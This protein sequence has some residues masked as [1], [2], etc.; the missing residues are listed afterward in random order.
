M[1]VF[2]PCAVPN[3]DKRDP[4]QNKI[5]SE[6]NLPELQYDDTRDI[7]YG[8]FDNKIIECK[9]DESSILSVD[10]VKAF[11]GVTLT[12]VHAFNGDQFYSV[13]DS[14]NKNYIAKGAGDEIQR[15]RY[16][17][18]YGESADEIAV[19]NSDSIVVSRRLRQGEHQLALIY[20]SEIISQLDT[21]EVRKIKE[22]ETTQVDS[23]VDQ[24]YIPFNEFFFT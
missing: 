12:A 16:P 3:L 14:Q 15:L 2:L 20:A 17:I 11:E 5:G 1:P 8:L 23:V 22:V 19:L 18:N 24:T 10:T 9:I 7:Y 13:R 6:I 21:I 4:I